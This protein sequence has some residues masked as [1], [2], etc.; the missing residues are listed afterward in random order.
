MFVMFF[1]LI[2]QL[3]RVVV[4]VAVVVLVFMKMGSAKL[5]SKRILL[6]DVNDVITCKLCKGYYVD[7]TTITECLHTFCKSCIV[8]HLEEETSVGLSLQDTSI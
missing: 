3:Y 2:F 1:P 6:K 7:A 4:V 8:S 5:P